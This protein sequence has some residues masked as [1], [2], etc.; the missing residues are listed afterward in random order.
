MYNFEIVNLELEPHLV[1]PPS[2]GKGGHRATPP[3]G[4]KNPFSG[5]CWIQEGIG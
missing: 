5:L 4:S 2:L 3:I 1:S